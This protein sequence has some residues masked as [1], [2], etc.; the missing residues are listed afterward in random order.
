MLQEAQDNQQELKILINKLNN[1]YNPT[2]DIK[3]QEK[4]DTKVCKKKVFFIREN[5]KAFKNGIFPY[6]DRF[7]VEEE[8]DK[9]SDENEEIDTTNMPDLESEKST[10]K[11]QGLKI[12]NQ[13]KW[14]ADYQLL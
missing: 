1:N 12:L 8:A 9:E 13:I 10:T 11:G 2:S 7:K 14:L 6:I 5:I 3:K 4:E